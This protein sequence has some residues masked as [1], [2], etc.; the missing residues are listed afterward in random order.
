MTTL[1]RIV[2]EQGYPLEYLLSRIRGRRTSLVL[3]WDALVR[4]SAP[5]EHLSPVRRRWGA[6]GKSPE[7][8]W[9]RLLQEYRWVYEQMNNTL[10]KIFGPFFLYVELRTLVIALRR[11]KNKIS[12]EVDELLAMS[13]L[14]EE[15]K[16]VLKT[17]TDVPAT[18][19]GL[20]RL[21]LPLSKEFSGLTEIL[22][23]EG[24]RGVEQRLT[25]TYLAHIVKSKLHPLIKLFFVRIIDARNAL[26]LYK[27]VRFATQAAPMYLP[28]G[29]ITEARFNDIFKKGDPLQT[30]SLIQ[31]LTGIKLDSAD[32]IRIERALY[33][34]ITREFRKKGKDPLSLGLILDYLWRCSVEAMNLVLLFYTKDL[35]RDEVAGEL[36]H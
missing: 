5:L 27:A 31:E 21:F 13:L 33:T 8:I 3:D 11:T 22:D 20:E 9:R 24:L 14:S 23:T 19:A 2:K 28:G 7:V 32:T 1:L 16:A 30:A 35:E 10:R 29:S 6:I 34:G 17:T 36:V 18:V 4:D 25:N 15:V 26:N 12:N